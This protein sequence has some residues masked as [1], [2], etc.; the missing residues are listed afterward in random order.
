MHYIHP[1]G[2]QLTVRDSADGDDELS[3]AELEAVTAGSVPK[4]CTYNYGP[5]CQQSYT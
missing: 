4:A 5:D 2:G 1:V 3:D